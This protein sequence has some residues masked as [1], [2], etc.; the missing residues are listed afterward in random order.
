MILRY[1]G[2]A[3]I[4]LIGLDSLFHRTVFHRER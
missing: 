2:A 3:L 4:V 1:I